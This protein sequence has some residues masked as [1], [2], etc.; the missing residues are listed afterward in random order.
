MSD[1][2]KLHIFES[3][4]GEDWFLA[5]DEEDAIALNAEMIGETEAREE[6]MSQI[7]DAKVFV[8]SFREEDVPQALRDHAEARVTPLEKMEGGGWTHRVWAPAWAWAGCQPRGF[9]ASRNY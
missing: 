8:M 7:P 4:S 3:G 6:G 1:D 9:L 5:Y 2:K